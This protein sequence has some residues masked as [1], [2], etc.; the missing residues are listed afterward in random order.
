MEPR[1]LRYFEATARHQHLGRAAAELAI[2]ESALSRSIA[3]L[4]KDYGP[5]F[6]RVGRGV[7]L[8]ECGRIL[9]A[10]VTRALA[11]LENATAEIRD[12][13]AGGNVLIALGFVPSLGAHVVPDLVARFQRLNP[14]VKFRF[15]QEGRERL[16][17]HLLAGDIDLCLA[18]HRFVESAIDWEPLY[19]EELVAIVPRHHPLAR[20]RRIA[21]RECAAEPMLAFKPG[22]ALRAAVDDLAHR[23]GFVPNIIFE[24]DDVPTILGLVDV[25][26]G[27]ALLPE[28]VEPTRGRAAI[29]RLNA[30]RWRT[31]GI[32]WMA[33]RYASPLVASFRQFIISR[34]NAVKGAYG[35]ITP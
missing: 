30:S 29:L 9:L 22:H 8:N 16:H 14:Q 15:V 4:E 3:R 11:E 1:G 35:T 7:Q 27:I 24:A 23:E 20:R 28:S 2:S 13:R 31:V 12:I 34:K 25:G 19:D 5:L 18:S 32:S 17:E 6:D 26:L 21:L 33:A 10:R